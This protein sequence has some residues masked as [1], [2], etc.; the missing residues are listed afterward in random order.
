M[1]LYLPQASAVHC[2]AFKCH[3][4]IPKLLNPLNLFSNVG[5]TTLIMMH[6]ADC[7]EA[8]RVE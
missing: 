3:V 1:M 2:Y 8:P 6:F 5:S 7:S 4:N